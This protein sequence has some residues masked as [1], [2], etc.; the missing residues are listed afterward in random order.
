[1]EEIQSR[2]DSGKLIGYESI[3][4]NSLM[5]EAEKHIKST[6]SKVTGKLDFVVTKKNVNETKRSVV[7]IVEFGIEHEIWWQ[8]MDQMLKYV[9]KLCE[10]TEDDKDRKSV[11]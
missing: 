4:E 9:T 5:V 7:M 11:V 3:D 1:M 8:K 10:A 2:M 6:S